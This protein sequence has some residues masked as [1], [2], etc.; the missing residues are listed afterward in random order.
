VRT[1]ITAQRCTYQECECVYQ[2]RK[3]QRAGRAFDFNHGQS[4]EVENDSRIVH[5][6]SSQRG[7]KSLTTARDENNSPSLITIRTNPRLP[8]LQSVTDLYT[9]RAKTVESKIMI[10]PHTKPKSVLAE[11]SHKFSPRSERLRTE[12]PGR[13]DQL[14]TYGRDC[15]RTHSSI[16]R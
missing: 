11:S 16:K 8:C 6:T 12:S 3:S 2:G 5:H 4:G 9:V 1:K 13:S 15:T 14:A 10:P 7:I